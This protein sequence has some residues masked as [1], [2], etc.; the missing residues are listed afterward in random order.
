MSTLLDV[1]VIGSIAVAV[2]GLIMG[3][4]SALAVDSMTTTRRETA[5][6]ALL[7]FGAIPLSPL[8]PV[9]VPILAVLLFRWLWREATS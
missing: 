8:W 5:R 9:G 1:W 7:G 2:L 6:N 3:A 4:G